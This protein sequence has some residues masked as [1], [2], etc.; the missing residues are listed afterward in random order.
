M[1]T[2]RVEERS[3]MKYLASNITLFPEFLG[4]NQSLTQRILIYHRFMTDREILIFAD[5]VNHG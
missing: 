2:M 3:A 1:A 4:I 5:E